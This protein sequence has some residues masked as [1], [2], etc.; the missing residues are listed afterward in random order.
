MHLASLVGTTV[1]SIWGATHSY[2]GFT[3][4]AQ[5]PENIV[6]VEM[7]CRPCSVY[8]NKKCY[9]P[10]FPYACMREISP[11]MIIERIMQR[12]KDLMI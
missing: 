2:A 9:R 11:S 5:S 8:G 6:Q 1:V 12:V 3:G 7:A 4:W 10:D